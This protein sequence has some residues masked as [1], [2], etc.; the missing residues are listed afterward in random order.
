[1]RW[2]WFDRL[3][4]FFMAWFV[5]LGGLWLGIGSAVFLKPIIMQIDDHNYTFVRETPFGDVDVIW[6]AELTLLDRGAASFDGFECS[7]N[8]R[9]TFQTAPGDLV[10]GKL[11]SW[12]DSCVEAGPPMVLRATYQ[13]MLLGVIPLR[14]VN[15][16]QDIPGAKK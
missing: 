8:G 1:M 7:G 4:L 15:F 6:R 12:A 16:V 2:Q 5:V 10:S 3:G 14:P 13:V 9:R 11:G